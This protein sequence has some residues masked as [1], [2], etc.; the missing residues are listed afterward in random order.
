MS[1]LLWVP[2]RSFVSFSSRA[3]ARHRIGHGESLKVPTDVRL[4]FSHRMYWTAFD[5]SYIASLALAAIVSGTP[6]TCTLQAPIADR[7]VSLLDFL[8]R[9]L[10]RAAIV[11]GA[12]AVP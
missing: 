4:A 8:G 10:R 3:S 1:S 5:I 2:V 9:R 7:F 6:D 11:A 12:D